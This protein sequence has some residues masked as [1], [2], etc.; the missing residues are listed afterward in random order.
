MSVQNMDGVKEKTKN[1]EWSLRCMYVCMHVLNG[2][3]YLLCC[4]S[5]EIES[6]AAGTEG[7]L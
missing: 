2:L 3:M 6:T 1:G 7:K 4:S 5:S